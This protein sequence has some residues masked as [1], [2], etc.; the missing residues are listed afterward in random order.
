MATSGTFTYTVTRDDII[1]SAMM[2]IVQ[3]GEGEDP[4]A[5]EI[6]DCARFLNLMTKQ[7][8]STTDFAP[9]LK[10]WTRRHADLLLTTTKGAYNLG[11]SG[12]DWTTNLIQSQT[13]NF[14]PL[15]SNVVV[16]VD[17]T[18]VGNYTAGTFMAVQTTQGDLWRTTVLSA[19]TALGFVLVTVSGTAPAQVN[20]GN[21][22]YSYQTKAQRPEKIETLYLRDSL[23]NDTPMR[24]FTSEEYDY[25][26]NK[27]QPGYVGDPMYGYYENQ[28]I[29]GVLYLDVAGA[30]DTTKRVRS[31]YLEPI[32]DF[33]N[34][35]D[36]P[37]YPANW[38]LALVW[39]LTK[40]IAPMF[41]EP[42]TKDM[43]DNHDSALA[44]AREGDPTNNTALFFQ[45]GL[46]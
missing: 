43:Q 15:G 26:P 12:D 25:L 1:R 20:I 31:T 41:E 27:Q 18:T 38:Y 10:V 9:G 5:Q 22:V 24:L 30:A 23:F 2:N 35:L 33:N 21:Y 32:Q 8:V 42:F 45:P 34:P 46:E 3:L 6:Q 44:M 19:T 40:Q 39:G 4:S 7:W 29:N 28:L 17:P 11:P 37:E 16:L 14:T 36:T 13:G